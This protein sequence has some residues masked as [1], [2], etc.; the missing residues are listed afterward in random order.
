MSLVQTAG[1]AIGLMIVAAVLCYFSAWFGVLFLVVLLAVHLGTSPKPLCASASV[2]QLAA[3]FASSSAQPPLVAS[4]APPPTTAP[5]APPP[6]A[7]PLVPQVQD[8][9]PPV[10]MTETTHRQVFNQ[11]KEEGRKV[12]VNPAWT[13]IGGGRG[14]TYDPKY[15]APAK[16]GLFELTKLVDPAAQADA[17]PC[18]LDKM[19][20]DIKQ[21]MAT[22]SH[23]ARGCNDPP[24]KHQKRMLERRAN[25]EKRVAAKLT[26][27]GKNTEMIHCA[28]PAAGN[29]R[30]AMD[31]GNLG[32]G[33]A[34]KMFGTGAVS[35]A[36]RARQPY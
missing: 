19:D 28:T 5:L 13:N 8:P 30:D 6:T 36:L 32:R 14:G 7:A 23:L 17:S 15:A 1:L 12:R 9:L 20:H 11:P 4:K 31:S 27:Y 22:R 21:M 35:A 16:E 26:R 3:L 24:G 2:E 34:S 25:I 18:T 29:W 33:R 10:V